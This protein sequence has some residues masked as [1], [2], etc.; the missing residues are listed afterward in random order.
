M[1]VYLNNEGKQM[2]SV[3]FSDNANITK[4]LH[5]HIIELLL[6]LQFPNQ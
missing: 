1:S 5:D 6:T 4:T 3:L 2:F